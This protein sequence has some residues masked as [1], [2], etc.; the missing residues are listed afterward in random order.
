MK[1]WLKFFWVGIIETEKDVIDTVSEI[2]ALRD[3][4]EKDTIVSLGKR[5]PNAKA[6]LTYLYSKIIRE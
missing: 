3:K 2:I 6:L 1:K 4:I 5:L